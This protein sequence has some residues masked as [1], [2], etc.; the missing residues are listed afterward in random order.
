MVA[1]WWRCGGVVVA[2]WWCCGGFCGCDVV[3]AFCCFGCGE[4]FTV[5]KKKG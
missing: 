1:L 5:N 2:L 3:V 4:V